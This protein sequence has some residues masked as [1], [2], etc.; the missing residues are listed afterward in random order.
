MGATARSISS[1]SKWVRDPIRRSGKDDGTDVLAL[2]QI[3]QQVGQFLHHRRG[4]S[5]PG[6]V[7]Q[8]LQD[9]SSLFYAQVSR[10]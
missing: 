1:T 8:D 2:L 7:E 6:I 10:C 5:S 4:E 3:V 9:A